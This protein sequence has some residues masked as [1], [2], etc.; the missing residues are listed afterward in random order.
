MAQP[1]Y[2]TL[3]GK[4]LLGFIKITCLGAK[5]QIELNGKPVLNW[6]QEPR[7]KIKD[8]ALEGYIGL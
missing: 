4:V 2:K 3:L 6:N 8:F 1:H 5:I 7:G